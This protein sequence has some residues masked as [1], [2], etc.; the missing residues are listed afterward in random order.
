MRNKKNGGAQVSTIEG[1]E[2]HVDSLEDEGMASSF[3]GTNIVINRSFTIRQSTA[4]EAPPKKMQTVAMQTETEQFFVY[5]FDYLAELEKK[6]SSKEI[7]IEE[8]L[9]RGREAMYEVADEA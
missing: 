4:S 2:A 6:I 1:E 8:I 5:I 9:I 7:T 3:G